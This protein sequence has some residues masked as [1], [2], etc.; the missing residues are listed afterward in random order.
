[1]VGQT[2]GLGLA[3]TAGVA[4]ACWAA[5]GQTAG[6]AAGLFGL[7]AAML[8]VVATRLAGPALA[9]GDYR[10]LLARWGVG[11]LLR[12]GGVVALPVAVVLGRDRFPALPSAIGY[13]AVLI[14]L[15]FLEMRRFR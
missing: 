3:L 6:V 12:V 7:W 13:L 8:Q 5:W 14:P 11:A 9:A 15:F 1:M 2:A 4:A 10:G